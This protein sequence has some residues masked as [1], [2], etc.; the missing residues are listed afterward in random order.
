M[1]IF[2]ISDGGRDL[3]VR[4]TCCRC[5]K[6]E[7]LTWAQAMPESKE[8]YIRNSCLPGGWEHWAGLLLFCSNCRNEFK[9]FLNPKTA[10][11]EAQ[12]DE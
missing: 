2:S 6:Q 7:M 10:E 5:K 3:M 8:G 4:F 12:K 9:Q 1:N 11:A